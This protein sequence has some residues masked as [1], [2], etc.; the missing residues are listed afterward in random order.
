VQVEALNQ[1]EEA[2]VTV[3]EKILKNC[4]IIVASL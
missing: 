4:K 2:N 1:E 3:E